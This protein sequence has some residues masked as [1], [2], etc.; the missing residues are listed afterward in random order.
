MKDGKDAAASRAAQPV[1]ARGAAKRAE[2]G[3]RSRIR[4]VYARYAAPEAGTGADGAGRAALDAAASAAVA[5]I[6]K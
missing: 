6:A 5:L 1:I 3:A 4:G 2:D